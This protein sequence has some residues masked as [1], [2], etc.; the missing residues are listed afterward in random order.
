[1]TETNEE[2][3]SQMYVRMQEIMEDTGAYVWITHQPQGLMYK[4]NLH[5]SIQPTGWL[6]YLDRYRWM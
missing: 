5:A 3:R 2:K 4:D 6:W 1:L